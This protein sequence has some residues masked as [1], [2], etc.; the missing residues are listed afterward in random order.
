M[1]L[2]SRKSGCSPPPKPKE[3][4]KKEKGIPYLLT[5]QQSCEAVAVQSSMSLYMLLEAFF[6]P[7]FTCISGHTKWFNADEETSE[8]RKEVEP[9]E[10]GK[11]TGTDGSS[12]RKRKKDKKQVCLCPRPHTIYLS[13]LSRSSIL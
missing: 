3:E 8:S 7:H 10:Q 12:A 13:Y 9:K 2:C 6:V 4:T 11:K 5:V 1:R